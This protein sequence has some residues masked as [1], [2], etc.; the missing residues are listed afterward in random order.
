M[1]EVLNKGQLKQTQSQ[2]DNN[3]QKQKLSKTAESKM[4]HNSNQS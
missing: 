1:S 4:S 2:K 3:L